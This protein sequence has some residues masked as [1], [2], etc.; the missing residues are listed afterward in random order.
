M[1]VTVRPS[2]TEDF[3]GV[4]GLLSQL[5]PEKSLNEIS[6]REA[7]ESGLS[8]ESEVFL[9]A[10]LDRDMVGFASISM[11]NSL[12]HGGLLA[13]VEALVSDKNSR[14]KGVGTALVNRVIEEAIQRRCKAVEIMIDNQAHA[15]KFVK[16]KGFQLRGN[17]FELKLPT[18]S[19]K[20]L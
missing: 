8:M 17:A 19:E 10:V 3:T 15:V 4:F 11:D 13:W 9:S 5:W 14:G 7:F 12:Y 18:F 2:V 1:S 20:T 16:N 6:M